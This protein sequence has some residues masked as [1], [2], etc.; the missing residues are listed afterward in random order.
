MA[1]F[2]LENKDGLRAKISSRG[3][4]LME[5]HVPDRQG[6]LE[7]VTLGFDEIE[8]YDNGSP[9]F[10]ALIGRYG[11]RIAGGRFS[12][13]GVEYS[14]PLNNGQNS[15][16][17][18]LVGFDKVEWEA[19]AFEEDGVK[20]LRLRYSSKDGE[21]GFPGKLDVTVMYRITDG[22][23]WIIDYE[24]TTN[25]P[26]VVNLTQ[27]AYFNLSG[28]QSGEH[29][30]HEAQI[31]ADLFTPV[32]DTLI[33][34][35]EVLAVAGTPFDFREAKTIGRDIEGDDE[36]LRRGKGFDH[37]FVLRKKPGEFGPAARVRDPKSGRVME[38]FTSEPGAQFYSGNFLDGS[39]VGKGGAVYR[40]RNGF[41]IETQHFPDSPNQAH[42]P[43]TRLDPGQVYRSKTAYRFSAE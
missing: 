36:Q 39:N 20:G 10:G 15:L 40:K 42:F 37:N 30:G 35:G 33:P 22:G 21:E 25:K 7:D 14:T 13:D 19:D 28:H 16:H 9:Y 6:T 31:E 11:N 4:I 18:G 1:I 34:T 17:G 32:D 27:H 38:V 8:Q 43:S 23:E 29:L 3:G 2:T 12:I 26:T 41:C 5:L 24:A